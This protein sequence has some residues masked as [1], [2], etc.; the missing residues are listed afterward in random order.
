MYL[1]APDYPGSSPRYPVDL[2][3]AP[4]ADSCDDDSEVY[5]TPSSSPA[6]PLSP[7][8]EAM[9]IEPH[10]YAPTL[11]P[12]HGRP[13][14][15]S[16]IAPPTL[17]RDDYYD[18]DHPITHRTPA[19]HSSETDPPLSE[20]SRSS[21]ESSL[22]S[23]SVYS[24][25]A[26]PP[27]SE[28]DG[29][30]LLDSGA[31]TSTH[32]T[33][34]FGS[35]MGSACPPRSDEGH[36]ESITAVSASRKAHPMIIDLSP[37][38]LP[39]PVFPRHGRY[40]SVPTPV[41][42]DED[43]A[44]DVRW[45][46]PSASA[47]STPTRTK[48]SLPTEPSRR[49][50][51]LPHPDL[52]PPLPADVSQ[53]PAP[54]QLDRQMFPELTTVAPTPTPTP[55]APPMPRPQRNSRHSSHR[56]SSMRMS[57][58]WEED[59]SEYSDWGT[60]SVDVSRASTPAP[61]SPFSEG[62]M[63]SRGSTPS[64][65]W[66]YS[67]VSMGGPVVTSGVGAMGHG[68]LHPE[69]RSSLHRRPSM[70]ESNLLDR[71]KGEPEP[72]SPAE[73]PDGMFKDY[74]ARRRRNHL[75]AVSLANPSAPSLGQQVTFGSS[76]PTYSIPA[77]F[78]VSEPGHGT[79]SGG[80]TSLTLP[81]AAYTGK[82]GRTR[83]SGQ[84]DLVRSGRAQSSMA[85]VEIV[86]GVANANMSVLSLAKTRRRLSFGL[87]GKKR[88]KE[89]ETPAHLRATLP[90]PVA[91]MAHIPP[92]SFVSTNHILVQ[93]F[94]VGLDALDSMIVQE[95]AEKRGA[96]A[97]VRGKKRGFIPGRAFVGRAVEC[98][99]DVDNA[100]CKRGEW[101]VGLLDVRKVGFI[102]MRLPFRV[103]DGRALNLSV[104]R[105]RRVYHHR[106][107]S[108]MPLQAATHKRRD[109]VPSST[110]HTCT[111]AVDAIAGQHIRLEHEPVL[112]GVLSPT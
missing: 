39:P 85:T 52:L 100:V 74:A 10:A 29:A 112:G 35:A 91:F 15:K 12:L 4:Q 55:T 62:Y 61:C 38:T 69:F 24:D 64:L 76:L 16:S 56:P 58:L 31:T 54:H 95:K 43:W 8:A 72:T 36:S 48:P 28:Q 86:R 49:R 71:F 75:R 107:S 50:P 84:V 11:L 41:R 20:A 99:F 44:K 90:L 3:V 26:S 78:P 30:S 96:V 87:T 23:E 110:T 37:A 1:K 51:R 2:T 101:V 79:N 57:A 88:E 46:V 33:T 6:P 77:P 22:S 109:T 34:P 83:L 82:S 60:S 42:K 25:T 70:S 13:R 102:A 53:L 104:R 106:A 9:L 47:P 65:G 14:L 105:A 98:G 67:G 18:F 89:S 93:V 27:V 59:E 97:T 81:H 66:A 45:L 32:I 94:A 17:S 21:S 80:Y 73:S 5:Y 19:R 40:Y 7:A 63:N 68:P 111:Y 108:D 103:T 92:P